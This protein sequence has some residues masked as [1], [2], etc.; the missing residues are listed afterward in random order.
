MEN[1]Y[2]EN[3]SKYLGVEMKPYIKPKALIIPQ[4][5]KP[6]EETLKKD[7][8]NILLEYLGFILKKRRSLTNMSKIETFVRKNLERL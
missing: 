1:K 8:E 5:E 4:T 6:K 2:E 3:L 7:V